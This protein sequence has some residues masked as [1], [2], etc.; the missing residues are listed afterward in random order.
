MVADLIVVGVVAIVVT[1]VRRMSCPLG[2][3]VDCDRLAAGT[4]PAPFAQPT[5]RRTRRPAALVSVVVGGAEARLAS[6]RNGYARVRRPHART[7]DDQWLIPLRALRSRSNLVLPKRERFRTG[8]T[9][10]PASGASAAT[11]N[12]A[13]AFGL[14]GASG[15]QSSAGLSGCLSPALPDG[16]AGNRAGTTSCL[17]GIASALCGPII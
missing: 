3:F 11:S 8:T 15:D 2:C 10:K 14:P 9:A 1:I 16:L 5:G 7:C 12:G 13:H 6:Q 17:R 4:S